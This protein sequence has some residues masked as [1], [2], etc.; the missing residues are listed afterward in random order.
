LTSVIRALMMYRFLGFIVR[1]EGYRPSL[2]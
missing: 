2:S 1:K